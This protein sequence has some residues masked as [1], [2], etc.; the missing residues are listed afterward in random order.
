M[1]LEA[2]AALC[3][4]LAAPELVRNRGVKIHCDNAGVVSGF[5]RGHSTESLAW[6]V[7][8][9]VRDVGRALNCPVEIH[10]VAVGI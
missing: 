1:F 6:S 10:K 7:L 9:A 3:G 8:K 4:L 5:S 2:V